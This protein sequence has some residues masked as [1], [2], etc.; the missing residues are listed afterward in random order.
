MRTANGQSTMDD[1]DPNAFTNLS[2]AELQRVVEISKVSSAEYQQG[3]PHLT[4]KTA[5]LC[6]RRHKHTSCVVPLSDYAFLDR[7][8]MYPDTPRYWLNRV[9]G[10]TPSVSAKRVGIGASVAAIVASKERWS[11]LAR[12]N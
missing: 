10:A 12:A 3:H 2:D 7:S 8:R 4:Y 1:I 9:F 5:G 6:S 11:S